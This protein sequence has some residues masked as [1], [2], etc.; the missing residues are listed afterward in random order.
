MEEWVWDGAITGDSPITE[1]IH[2][3]DNRINEGKDSIVQMNHPT[4][5]DWN[6]LDFDPIMASKT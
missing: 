2:W 1:I 6:N 3:V 4:V 5:T